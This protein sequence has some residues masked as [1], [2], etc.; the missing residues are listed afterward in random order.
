MT[1]REK[2]LAGKP[3]CSADKEL[4]EQSNKAK[5]LIKEYNNLSAE[6]IQSRMKR[7]F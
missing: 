2:M 5:A 4:R 1:E 7:G 6:D 3:Y